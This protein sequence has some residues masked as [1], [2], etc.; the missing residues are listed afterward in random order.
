METNDR[1][2][3]EAEW[4]AEDKRD[5]SIRLSEDRRRHDTPVTVR[6][7]QRITKSFR[8]W[9]AKQKGPCIIIFPTTV[10]EIERR[11]PLKDETIIA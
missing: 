7:M 8:K 10:A 11:R 6:R 1:W 2:M 9:F 4:D 5:P 3:D